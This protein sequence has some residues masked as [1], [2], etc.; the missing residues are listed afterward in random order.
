[1][2]SFAQALARYLV[3][4]TQFEPHESQVGTH[5]TSP[6]CC[7]NVTLPPTTESSMY[8]SFRVYQH[9]RPLNAASNL[10][11]CN[12]HTATICQTLV[13]AQIIFRSCSHPCDNSWPCTLPT[14]LEQR[15]PPQISRDTDNNLNG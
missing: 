5:R 13:I 8:V 4:R 15:N 9:T 1:M 10:H 14:Y 2:S 12:S 6:R 11:P 3:F 7:N